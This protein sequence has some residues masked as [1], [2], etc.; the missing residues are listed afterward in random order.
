[1]CFPGADTENWRFSAYPVA[2]LGIA[3]IRTRYD[4]VAARVAT[5]RSRL[6]ATRNVA[7]SARLKVAIAWR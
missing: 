7:E 2:L 6:A 4:G 1:M 3:G 5:E